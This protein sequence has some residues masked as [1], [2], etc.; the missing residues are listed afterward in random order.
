MRNR[1]YLT[2]LALIAAVAASTFC[3]REDPTRLGRPPVV[4]G[5]S[6]RSQLFD[7]ALG[8][9]LLFNIRA[10]DPDRS[11]LA[12]RYLLGDS[13]V[14]TAQTWRYVVHDTGTVLVVGVVSD[15]YYESRITWHVTRFKPIN[16]PPIIQGFAP[17]EPQPTMIVGTD[18]QFAVTA[19]DPE[20]DELSYRFTVDGQVVSVEDDFIYHAVDIGPRAVSAQVS[21]GENVVGHDWLLHVTGIP[22]T[23]APAQVP[24]TLVETGAEPGEV[25]I[26]WTA[27]GKDGMN[28]VASD[29]LVR[30]SPSP[31]LTK[32]DWDRATV[33]PG[34][35]PPAPAGSEMAMTIV[36]ITPA[37]FTH[38]AV[39]AE[40]DFGNLSP[41]G[42]SPG[43]YSRGMGISGSV[44]DAISDAPIEGAVLRL[45][46]FLDVSDA[47]GAWSM[48]DLPPID[49]GLSVTDDDTPGVIGTYYDYSMS[50]TVVHEDEL[51][52]YLLPDW[53]LETVYYN[54]FRL[55]FRAMTDGNTPAA[56][57]QRRWELPIALHAPSFIVQG[58]DY[59]DVIR[60]VAAEVDTIIG[61]PVFM[62]VDEPPALGVT[63][64]YSPT[65]FY[66]NYR[67]VESTPDWYP[68]RGAIALRTVYTPAD[69]ELLRRVVR[70]ELGHALGLNHSMDTGHAMV[71]GTSPQ[72]SEFSADERAVIRAR[73]NIPRGRD[74]TGFAAE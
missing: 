60:E 39:R 56:A 61:Q 4:Q 10:M 16:G 67:T 40:D 6:P 62:L 30:T 22:D 44:R 17:V 70:H 52:M 74:M 50:Y 2:A 33:R 9:T 5:F 19:F 64:T 43:V 47:A 68:V 13:V 7:A 20:G 41:I 24:I 25:D 28:G 54:S 69:L 18:L 35:P 11:S 66:D 14:S 59:A 72:V 71:G 38:L 12:R 45:A 8:D 46:S 57:Q 49:G 42:V 23:I 15:D 31:I 51:D 27:V 73:Y 37:R 63:V 21:D 26:R 34:V 3:G 65:V 55:F 32:E 36:G 53:P 58:L 29:Y 1:R 48:S